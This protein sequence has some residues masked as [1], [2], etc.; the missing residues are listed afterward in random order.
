MNNITTFLILAA[1]IFP[2]ALAL[3]CSTA[4]STSC[5]VAGSSCQYFTWFNS[6]TCIAPTSCPSQVVWSNATFNCV[7]CASAD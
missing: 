2:A 4:D 7:P 1:F 6:S 3:N 5:G